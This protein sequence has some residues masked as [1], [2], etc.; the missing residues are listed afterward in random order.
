MKNDNQYLICAKSV[1]DNVGDPDIKFG[2]DGVCDYYKRAADIRDEYVFTN[3]QVV[4]NL[5][6]LSQSICGGK[7]KGDYDCLIGLSGGV[8]SSYVALIAKRLNMRV[9]AVHFDN[10]WNSEIA[11]HNIKTIVSYLGCELITYV[12]NWDEYA[13]L[14]RSFFEASVVDIEMITDNSH[15]A[16][17]LDIA[18]KYRIPFILSGGNF[19]TENMMPK[20][21]SWN[22]QDILNI[23]D[24]HRKY[25]KVPL[26]TYKMI[27]DMRW[28]IVTRTR[29]GPNVLKPLNLIN[30][31]KD[32]AMENL[33]QV[34]WRY[35]GGKHYESIFTKF[36]QAYVLPKKFNIDKRKVHLSALILNEEITRDEAL[37][38]LKN[39]LYPPE[40]FEYEYDYVRKKLGYSINSFNRIIGAPPRMH[41]EYRSNARIISALKRMY[42]VIK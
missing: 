26:N 18:K 33:E 14:Q 32:R 8:D 30:Y 16:V 22:K 37:T 34:G 12:V 27:S 15:K 35:Y 41:T 20:T 38:E 3:S 24:I 1:M 6:Q 28:Q 36:Y 10:G 2:E 7:R 21:W 11:V 31:R 9:L 4:N 17:S 13:D 39:D 5:S 42:Q 40:Q 29:Y 25:G 23:K 19:R